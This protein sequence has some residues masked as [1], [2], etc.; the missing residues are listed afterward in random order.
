MA[1][2]AAQYL[3]VQTVATRPLACARPNAKLV[4]GRVETR[5]VAPGEVLIAI[6]VMDVEIE[7][8]HLIETV[9]GLRVSHTD[10]DVIKDAKAAAL[11]R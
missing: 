5:W 2:A 7:D 1:E 11:A 8:C 9:N 3:A 10:H 6:S 4:G